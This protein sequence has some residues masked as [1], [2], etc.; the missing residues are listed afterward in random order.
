MSKKIL[1]IWDKFWLDSHGK[2]IIW[3][4]PNIYL[5]SWAVLTIISLIFTGTVSNIFL[6]LGVVAIVVWS[7]LEI[8]KGL[9]YFRRL[10]GL[11]VLIVVVLL[12]I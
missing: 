4:M 2:L 9:N 8:F 3:Q 12:T 6:W 11:I 1:T 10:L 7:L 5:I